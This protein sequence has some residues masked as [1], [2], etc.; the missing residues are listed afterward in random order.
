MKMSVIVNRI[1]FALIVCV[2]CGFP[3]VFSAQESPSALNLSLAKRLAS[4][5][6]EYA[7]KNNWKI[8]VA[9]VNAEGNLIYFERA[10]DAM[11]GS[12]EG[13]MEKAKSANAYRRP[14]KVFADNV[15]QGR[16]GLVTL[17]NVVAVEGG[18][19]ILLNGAHVGAIGVSGAHAVE[20]E[21]CASAAIE[22]LK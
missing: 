14:T 3:A 19:P 1:A 9:I 11:Q 7:A 12:I 2:L 20:D 8:S 6:Q 17:K 18:L 22:K 4:A 5:A 21:A 15:K 16:V 13:A 10:D